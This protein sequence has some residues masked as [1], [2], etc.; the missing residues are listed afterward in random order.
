[1]SESSLDWRAELTDLIPRLRRYALSLARNADV[2]DDLLQSTLEQALRKR[3]LYKS[4]TNFGGW[5]LRICRNLW[6]DEIRKKKFDAGSMEPEMAE[7][8]MTFDGERQ[9]AERALLNEVSA[10]CRQG[11]SSWPVAVHTVEATTNADGN[12][13]TASEQRPAAIAAF[14]AGTATLDEAHEQTLIAN[15]W[16]EY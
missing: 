15:K 9:M 7:R 2:A 3:H 14:L 11:D 4:G 10:A 16:T 8:M 12:Y 13:Q 6:I 1:M 5:M